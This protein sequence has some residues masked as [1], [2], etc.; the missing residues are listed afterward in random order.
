MHI[1]ALITYAV[2]IHGHIQMD[3]AASWVVELGLFISV[4]YFKH[5]QKLNICIMR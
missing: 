4:M 2:L 1:L 5:K 3:S